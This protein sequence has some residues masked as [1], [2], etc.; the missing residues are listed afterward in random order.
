MHLTPKPVAFPLRSGYEFHYATRHCNPTQTQGTEHSVSFLFLP[1]YVCLSV[2]LSV[3]LS[4]CLPALQATNM[5]TKNM[6]VHTLRMNSNVVH[7][8]STIYAGASC[9]FCLL[10]L[11]MYSVN[12]LYA[13]TFPPTPH[14]LSDVREEP[15]R[16]QSE[17]T[18][19]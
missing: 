11:Q 14:R 7:S 17:A 19:G 16:L 15:P 5:Q 6:C 1:H 13:A 12:H 9:A 10:S 8:T 2:S 18:V 3:S 4:A